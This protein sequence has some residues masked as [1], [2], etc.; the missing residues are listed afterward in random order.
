MLQLPQ[1]DIQWII[2]I[3]VGAS[4]VASNGL[5]HVLK[6][7]LFGWM[8]ARN[9]PEPWWAA[10]ALRIIACAAGAIAGHM[11]M[12]NGLGVLVGFSAGAS[13]TAIVYW[14]KRRARRKLEESGDITPPEGTPCPKPDVKSDVPKE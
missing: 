1:L 6:L 13:N 10:M 14:I 2:I 12:P 9:K 5:T 3:L 4:A 7:G 8:K 11:L